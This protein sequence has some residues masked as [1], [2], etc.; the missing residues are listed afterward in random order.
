[1]GTC[2]RTSTFILFLILSC[3][4]ANAQEYRSKEIKPIREN[5]QKINHTKHWTKIREI[6][7][8]ETTEGG[9]ATFYYLN[10]VLTKIIVRQFGETFKSITEYYLL[11]G[12][13]SFVLDNNYKYNRPITYDSAAMKANKDDQVWDMKKSE[14]IENRSYFSNGKLIHQINN[15]DCGSPFSEEY[16]AEEGKT[17][18]TE[19]QKLLTL[20]KRKK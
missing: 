19:F 14:F 16:L 10:T 4:F 17:I 3:F 5:V 2:L 18:L 15:Q 9:K 7:L 8:W 13:L 1:M 6:D 11:N 12:K 20:I